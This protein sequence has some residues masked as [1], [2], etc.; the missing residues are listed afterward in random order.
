M[1]DDADLQLR[2]IAAEL[3]RVEESAR[4][5]AQSQFEQAKF[6]RVST[7]C[8]AYPH[9]S[10]RLSPAGLGW[11]PSTFGSWLHGWRLPLRASGPS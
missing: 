6:W 10:W 4:Y 2:S 7:C 1:G 5:S 9:R 11:R 3:S 8:S